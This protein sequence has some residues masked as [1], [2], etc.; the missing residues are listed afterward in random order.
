MGDWE[1]APSGQN[2]TSKLALLREEG[3]EFDV[4]GFLKDGKKWFAEFVV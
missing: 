3:V 1:Q 4:K 2:Q